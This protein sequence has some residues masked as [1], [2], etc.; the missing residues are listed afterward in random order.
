MLRPV[1]LRI[2][3]SGRERHK[4]R[5]AAGQ[6][7]PKEGEVELLG[8]PEDYDDHVPRLEAHVQEHVGVAL[9]VSQRY[10]AANGQGASADEH[11]AEH[12]VRRFCS[13]F[14]QRR[15]GITHLRLDDQ[16][17]KDVIARRRG[18]RHRLSASSVVPPK[19]SVILADRSPRRR[20]SMRSPTRPTAKCVEA[21]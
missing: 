18:E 6:H 21:C 14:A 7:G 20:L 3:F 17:V 4:A 10:A 5:H 11:A 19:Q 15:N 13:A 9:A 1:L 16:A 2:L 8:M 12:R